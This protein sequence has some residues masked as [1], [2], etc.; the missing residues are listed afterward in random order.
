VAV[1]ALGLGL[2]EI[3][4]AV[5]ATTNNPNLV[6]SLIL[7]GAVVVP[8]AFVAFVS[9]LKLS[10]DVGAGTLM[11]VA[12]VGGVVGVVTAGLLEYQT[13]RHLGTLPLIGVATVE[14]ATKLIAPLVVLLVTPHRR[15]ADGLLVGVACG[16]GF[17]V[18][19]T[20]GYASVVLMQSHR[21]LGRVASLLLERGFFSPATHIAWT[22]ITAA[23]LWYAAAGRWQPRS[24]IVLAGVFVTAVA[25]HTG[26][27][28]TTSPF[29]FIL[30]AA[31]SLGLLAVTAHR[32]E[33]AERPERADRAD[34]AERAALPPSRTGRRE[35]SDSTG[36][37]PGLA[38]PG[39]PDAAPAPVPAGRPSGP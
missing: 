11:V 9:S 13:L 26:W 12:F 36:T 17:A 5:L 19:E 24:L 1:L 22:G 16:A 18:M 23:A 25:L 3:I 6:P 38:V 7:L 33:R 27:D 31:V 14:E 28:A 10:F 15:R 2:F 39:R 4:R 20:M 37:A 21:D 32:L 29:V 34:R 8:A 30:V 35:S